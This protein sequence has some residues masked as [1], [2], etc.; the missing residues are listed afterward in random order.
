MF[1]FI[2]KV[3]HAD[4]HRSFK[5]RKLLKKVRP[6]EF[7][8]KKFPNFFIHVYS[9]FNESNYDTMRIFY[10][11]CYLANKFEDHKCYNS[12][13]KS[14]YEWIKVENVLK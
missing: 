7:F 11:D 2:F 12:Q 14:S 10:C 1:F 8:L 9:F 6:V 3:R 5:I 13:K 4:D